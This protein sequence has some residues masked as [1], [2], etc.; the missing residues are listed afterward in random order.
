MA[1]FVRLLQV[2][3]TFR[4]FSHVGSATP[5]PCLPLSIHFHSH[6]TCV[7]FGCFLFFFFTQMLERRHPRLPSRWIMSLAVCTRPC[8]TE[9]FPA[10][11]HFPFLFYGNLGRYIIFQCTE[12]STLVTSSPYNLFLILEGMNVVVLLR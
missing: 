11:T 7:I 10:I 5:Q 12:S 1:S 8:S 4:L 3:G 6:C 9:I 2:E